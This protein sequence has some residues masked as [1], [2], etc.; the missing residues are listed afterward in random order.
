[1]STYMIKVSRYRSRTLFHH[2]LDRTRWVDLHREQ[3]VKPVDLRRILRE[4]LAKRIGQVVRWV[5]GLRS[6]FIKRSIREVVFEGTHN[7]KD[8]LSTRRELDGQ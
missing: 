2:L 1:M 3:V 4:L 7:Q 8:R 5:C 6:G